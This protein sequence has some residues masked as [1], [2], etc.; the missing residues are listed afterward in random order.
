MIGEVVQVM[1][2]NPSID[3]LALDSHSDAQE[4][5]AEGLSKARGEKVKADIV[6]GGVDSGRIDVRP[7]G[8]SSPRIF[9]PE[10]DLMT[11]AEEMQAARGHNRRVEFR[12]VSFR[13]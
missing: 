1:N 8:A 5:D 13:R 3:T 10:I 11:T 9:P 4:H 7:H 6:S 2:E 12:V